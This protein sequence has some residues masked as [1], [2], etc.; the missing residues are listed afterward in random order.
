[1]IRGEKRGGQEEIQGEKEEKTAAKKGNCLGVTMTGQASYSAWLKSPTCN[2]EGDGEERGDT[3]LLLSLGLTRCNYRG[4]SSISYAHSR[5]TETLSDMHAE[6]GRD[7]QRAAAE[8]QASRP[9]RVYY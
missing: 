6:R 9:Q 2:L 1:M 3:R 8:S 4:N 5:E 7:R